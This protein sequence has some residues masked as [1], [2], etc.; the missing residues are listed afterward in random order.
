[1][2]VDKTSGILVVGGGVA[3]I[4]AA[5]VLSSKHR[6]TLLERNDYLGGHTNTRVV[7][8]P[9]NE[10]LSVDTG[11]IVCNPRNYPNF[12]RFLDQIG[13]NRQ[14]SD[15]SFGFSCEKTG[16]Q[17]M[18]PSIAEFLRAPINLC[19][20]KFLSMLLEQQRFN[21]RALKDLRLGRLGE[22]PLGDYL[23]RVGTSQFFFDNYLAP[24]IGSIWSAPDS[25]ALQFP[26]LSFLT[27]FNNHGM[28]EMSQRPQ[29]QTI[30]GGSHSYIKAFRDR[31]TGELRINKRA[32]KLERT[33]NGVVLHTEG[34]GPELFN[35]V[36]IAT[37][38]DEALRLLSD[39]SDQEKRMLGSWSY[40][41]NRT[42][43]HTDASV[44]GPRK[45]LWA[46]WNYKRR[47]SSKVDSPV[48]ITYYMNKLQRLRA[49]RDYF[50]T[51]NCADDIDARSILY[52]VE[53]THPIYTPESPISQEGIRRLNGTR[54]TFFCGAYM[55]YGFH[56][57]AVVSGLEVA[58]AFG[59]SL[60]DTQSRDQ[61]RER[62]LAYAN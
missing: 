25:N 52:E 50:V 34:A 6:V 51:L 2:L 35:K 56:E 36:V 4:T 40:S 17:Y 61:Q 43:L 26:A 15:M 12:Y 8:D 41:K 62:E 47:V 3:G 42:V 10:Q 39:P 31:F 60:N 59:L 30:V 49:A 27:F 29:W 33:D 1:V 54:H 18:G 22:V 57:D 16:L 45:R 53:Y 24:L 11:F 21:R 20:P 58:K 46:A 28:L 13:V 37:H 44:L 55:R 9:L 38:A 48:A 32:V 7:Q 19:S 23:K 5:Y 14:D